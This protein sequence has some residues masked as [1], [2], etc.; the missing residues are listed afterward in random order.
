MSIWDVIGHSKPA[1]ALGDVI[2]VRI[3]AMAV[4]SVAGVFQFGQVHDSG[5]ARQ[6]ALGAKG[7]PAGLVAGLLGMQRCAQR[8]LH[9]PDEQ[10]GPWPATPH[11]FLV[12]A[13]KDC[14]L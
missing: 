11:S 1:A 10:M 7:A 8:V 6:M 9:V 12:W 2:K 3:R 14:C 5:E 13:P 4:E